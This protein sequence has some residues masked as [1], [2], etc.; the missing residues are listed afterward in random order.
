MA[1]VRLTAAQQAAVEDRDGALLVS[2]AA[3]SGKTRV[4][5]ER[6]M[7]R[8][9]DPIHP[10]DISDF[11]II[12]YTKAAAA[13]LRTKIS[14]ELGKRL[15][16]E[17][18]SRHLQRQLS[19]VCLTE[20]STVHAFCAAL[21]RSYAHL[22]GIPSDF[23]VGE[24]AECRLLRQ[25]TLDALLDAAY[26][27]GGSDLQ[28]A[29]DQ[30][31]AGRDDRGLAEAVEALYQAAM[32]HPYPKQWLRSC[33][34]ALEL[35]EGTACG[36][37]VWGA[38]LLDRF[39]RFVDQQA[40]ALAQAAAEMA[41]DEVLEKTYRPCFLESLERVQALHGLRDWDR[42][43]A[44][45]PTSFGRLTAARGYEDKARLERWKSVRSRCLDGLREW[46]EVFA[47][48]DRQAMADLR[49]SAPAVRGAL[50]LTERLMERFS[51]E[52]RRRRILDFG[53]LEQEAIGLLLDRATGRPTAA[54][55][56]IAERFEEI[57]VDEY[58]DSNE[59][60]ECIFSAVSRENRNRFLVGDVKQSIYRFRLADPTIFLEKYRTFAPADKAVPGEPRKRL[61]QENFRSRPEILSAVNDVFRTVMSE[62]VGDLTYDDDA[63]LRPGR[64]FPPP[65]DTPVELHC[66]DLGDG[67]AGDKDTVEAAFV[68]RRIAELLQ[69]GQLETD[70]G[71]RPIRPEDIVI[72]LRSVS[73]AAPA[74][75]SA[76]QELGI[77]VA[78]DR[79]EN[80]LETRE[81]ETLV[82]ILQ[83]IDNPQRDIP[84]VSALT[85]PAFGFTA[86]DLASIRAGRRS[87]S[88]YDAL[89]AAV[90]SSEKAASF[91]R[92]LEELREEA[93]WLPLYQLIRLVCRRTRLD[94]VFGAM[95]GGRRRRANLEEFAAFAAGRGQ[96]TLMDFLDDLENRRQ[97]GQTIPTAD[98]AGGTAVQL[99]SIHKSKG[100]EFPI[101][102]LPD[103]SRRFNLEDLRRNVMTHPRLLAG[104]CL[105]DSE[106]GIRFP[107]VAR[108]AI[109]MRQRQENL[110]EELR[111]LYVAMTRA[112]QRLIMTYCSRYLSAELESAA[113]AGRPASRMYTASVKNPGMWVLAAAIS[114]VEAGELRAAVDGPCAVAALEHPWRIRLHAAGDG[115]ETDAAQFCTAAAE[116]AALP[117]PDAEQILR[118]WNFRY[119]HTAAAAVPSKV[120]ATQL[121]GRAMDAEAQ[122]DAEMLLKP[123]HSQRRRPRFISADRGLTP[124]EKGT[125][126]HLFLQFADY[127]ACRTEAGIAAEVLR[128]RREEFLTDQQADAV[129]QE[130]MLR[131]FQSTLGR[132][133]FSAPKVHREMKFSVLTD[134]ALYDRAASGEQILLQGVVDCLLEY[135]SGLTVI[136]FKTDAVRPGSEAERAAYYAGQLQAYALALSRIF[137]KPVRRRILYFL[138]TGCVLE[139][140]EA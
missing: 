25:R 40:G 121:K 87:G 10:S 20:I 73:S 74:Y 28:A 117:L 43:E 52:K 105:V 138:R 99:M 45:V 4:L 46:H 130:Q 131:L 112:K 76:L 2:A 5:V 82:S 111:V 67:S 80:L 53:D 35:P 36:D 140:P 57:L 62:E 18:G 132:E 84:L 44:A 41:G 113:G 6:L 78:S 85:S 13:E 58:Q 33:R 97:Q 47:G 123:P 19:L 136:D 11:L 129:E 56:E 107:T 7:D 108:R 3:G 104:C 124:A 55:R 83:T 116:T 115:A 66:V 134:A 22:R 29:A 51:A 17:P 39:G 120:T 118:R 26:A 133:I 114:R 125:A 91:L 98:Q 137:Q 54:A 127:G 32:C 71:L 31:G 94:A 103:L 37:T 110:S 89:T 21:L 38:Y 34:A 92:Q 12:T 69:E 49:A 16:L 90:G 68:A 15:A 79:G 126:N 48:G 96:M 70:D 59:I 60:Q 119:A 61:L 106:A 135:D 50:D 1:D 109:A 72:L 42:L 95:E 139:V 65:S 88:F 101:V 14:A 77:P 128:M 23:R 27:E 8:V 122:E 30:L 86:D 64:P 81:V 63:V 102:I 93:R 75:I 24:E 9:C 100:L